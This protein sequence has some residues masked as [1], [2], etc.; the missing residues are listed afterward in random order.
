[1]I[2]FKDLVVANP[3]YGMKVCAQCGAVVENTNVA[4]TAHEEFHRYQGETGGVAR[5]LWQESQN[6]PWWRRWNQ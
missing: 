1:M 6:Q 4:L 3:V 2:E 5:I